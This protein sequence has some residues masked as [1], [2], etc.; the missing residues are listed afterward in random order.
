MSGTSKEYLLSYSELDS[1]TSALAVKLRSLVQA[2]KP[3]EGRQNII[4][5]YMANSPAFYVSWLAVLKAGYAF[6]PLPMD[7]PPEQLRGIVEEVGA[8]LILCNG[9]QVGGRPWD[10][11]YCDDDELA[12]CLDVA[13]FI[14]HY[15]DGSNSPI[16]VVDAL[17]SI[18]E[19]DLAYVMY[20]SG[21][22]GKPKGVRIHHLAAACSIASHCKFIPASFFRDGF[23][24]FQF[25]A[26][27][28]DPSIMEIFTTWWTGGTLCGAPREELLTDPEAAINKL[29]ATI[30]MA[31]P[32]MAS[33]LRPE[34][35]PTLRTLWTM[36]EKLTP[37]VIRNFSSDSPLHASE[38]SHVPRLQKPYRLLNFYGPTETSINCNV[39]SDFSAHERGSIIGKAIDT[40]S[41]LILDANT[42]RPIPV[43]LGFSGELAIGGPQVSQGYL[44]RPDQTAA[45]FV[46]S[47]EYGRLYRT[48]DRARI[49]KSRQGDLTVEFLGRLTTDQVK[50]SGRRVELGQIESVIAAVNGVSD[51][52]AIVHSQGGAGQGSEQVVACVV[53]DGTV[54]ETEL[55]SAC[56]QAA[57]ST[58][59]SF[60]RPASYI[61]L[62]SMPRSR[63]GKTDRKALQVLANEQS[64]TSAQ[65][66]LQGSHH[67]S[68]SPVKDRDLALVVDA[69]SDVCGVGRNDIAP[70]TDLLSIGLDSLRAVRFLQRIR[71]EGITNLSVATLLSSRTVE[72]IA[73][74]CAQSG[75]D[76][77][78]DRDACDRRLDTFSQQH[79]AQCAQQLGLDAQEVEAVL[80]TTA[81]QSGMIASFLR[82]TSR[83]SERALRKRYINHSIYHQA[84]GV[85]HSKL[86]SAWKSALSGPRILRTVFVPVDDNLS[87]FGQCILSASSSAAQLQVVLYET[88][89]DDWSDTIQKAESD[90]EAAIEL[91]RPP[92]RLSV[93]QSSERR[94]YLLSL[95]HGIFDGGS[96]ELILR[97]VENAYLDRPSAPRTEV[98]VPV[99]KHFTEA[100]EA[101]RQYWK[102]QYQDF[103][104]VPFPCVSASKAEKMSPSAQVTEVIGNVTLEKL[105]A[106]SRTASVSPLSIL[107]AAWATILFA[108]SGSTAEVSFGSVLSDRLEDELS[109]CHAPTF[110]V[111][112]VKLSRAHTSD[113]SVR[114]VLS[115]LTDRNAEALPHH[116]IPLSGLT[117]SDGSLPYDTLLAFQAFDKSAGDSSIWSK[118]EYPPME[119]DFAVMIEIW[120]TRTGALRL[121]AT[122]T[123]AHLDEAG[124][125]VMLQQLDELVNQLCE[126]PAMTFS[127]APYAVSKY[128]RSEYPA[129]SC[130]DLDK[131]Q[132]LLHC[133]FEKHAA[134]H[135]NTTA[136]LFKRSLDGSIADIDWSFGRLSSLADGFATR[137]LKAFGPI[138]NQPVM[139]CMEKC[140][141]LYI[142]VLGILKAGTG[143]CPIDPYSPPAR[144]HA[145]MERTGSKILILSP[146][147]SKVDP[148]AIPG[149]VST[150]DIDLAALEASTEAS[151][152]S[153]FAVKRDPSHLA[154]LIFTSGTTG[155]PKGV[156][157]THQAGATAMHALAKEV[158]SDT[159][160]GELRCMQ[161]S[162]YTFD[163]FVQ[164]LF[165]TWTLGGT[166]ISGTREL[167]LQNFAELANQTRAT[168]AHLTPAFSA[169]VSRD[170]IKTL[171]VVTMIGEKLTE[172][173]AEDWG[174]NMRAFN[175]YGK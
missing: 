115:Y 160:T 145:I 68:G 5:A 172:A 105:S 88:K 152:L 64:F 34:R 46:T 134:D 82:S 130:N 140:P 9:P 97:D 107:Q 29:G 85:D 87:P 40:C 155:L 139:I 1:L 28:F 20:T 114:D 156:P 15:Q 174:T 170:K 91:D 123:H 149:G 35:V 117:T 133:A 73:K 101:T 6:A 51:V 67:G 161:F 47:P 102:S 162:Q 175:T 7:A 44:N 173:V 171:E 50:L 141:E 109:S 112:P 98:D 111:A 125:T 131:S 124:A 38:A 83:G 10:A 22:T 119:H 132:L 52:V 113:K 99:R 137:L 166:V 65:D 169:T 59:A 62:D 63:S 121:R 74:H 136:L 128:L 54:Q 43:P 21:S 11:W 164:D 95:F 69:L 60:M 61:L 27:T 24:W 168:H 2:V 94:T 78:I 23:R 126:Q 153:T 135:P 81:T 80:P 86:D 70:S 151:E 104:L 127:Q 167:M 71:D 4:P 45:A 26:P 92:F 72:G 53:R 16:P 66:S 25:A 37:K 31:T 90:A 89:A 118:A 36:G 79:H 122:Y 48:G 158:P 106:A 14:T 57:E 17:P 142:A 19:T 3:P 108:Y 42:K 157:I 75:E 32:S 120:P 58:L 110:V 143:W 138:D 33:V 84:H 49:V 147:S 8:S 148:T 103:E 150:V 100:T 129:V 163:V 77:S 56:R 93:I 146:T 18:I 159:S 76:Q 13:A 30:M 12:T 55:L 154:Y 39:V 165:Y 96:L 144:Q 41:I 116:H